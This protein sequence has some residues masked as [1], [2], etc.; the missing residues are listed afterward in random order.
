MILR[1]TEYGEEVLRQKG[2]EVAVFDDGLRKLVV[3][4]VETMY[5]A[6]GIGLAAQQVGLPLQVCV[7]DVSLL[8]AAD[9]HYELDG[10]RPPIDLIMPM[11]L[12][13]PVVRVLPSRTEQEEEGCLSF[14][15]VR[16]MV[17]RDDAI[18]VDFRDPEGGAHTLLAQGWFARVVQHE[19]DHLNGVLFI[20]HMDPRQLRSLENKIKRIRRD[21]RDRLKKLADASPEASSPSS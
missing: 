4:M 12:I 10:K 3:D 15:G 2:S 11:A 14:P 1:V 6:E 7:I 19:V 9:L 18:A 16:G 21:S 5:A 13:N 8:D 20:D 17:P